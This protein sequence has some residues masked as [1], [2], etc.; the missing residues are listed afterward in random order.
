VSVVG[1]E[2][3]GH[4][5]AGSV[6]SLIAI[7]IRSAS[8]A[9]WAGRLLSFMAVCRLA[10]QQ[11][12]QLSISPAVAGLSALC[13]RLGS[14]DLVRFGLFLS[15]CSVVVTG[16]ALVYKPRDEPVTKGD[17]TV[18]RCANN[19]LALGG[20]AA[21][22]QEFSDGVGRHKD[23]LTDTDRADLTGLNGPI[24]LSPSDVEHLGCLFDGA[25]R[26]AHDLANF[27]HSRV[28]FCSSGIRAFRCFPGL[29]PIL[30]Y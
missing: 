4:P 14:G 11:V 15:C 16:W 22:S 28:H 30:Q 3:P 25:R 9:A 10:S 26:L 24:C 19:V 13:L 1:G 21:G 18:P 20:I 2:L 29:N 5:A 7:L 27:Q 6:E 12:L 17:T 23:T 8:G